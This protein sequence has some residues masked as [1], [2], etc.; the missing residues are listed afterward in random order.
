[1]SA[2]GKDGEKNAAVAESRCTKSERR[3]AIGWEGWLWEMKY[4]K[5][6]FVVVENLEE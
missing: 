2:V 3:G 1:M 6:G 4:E 5:R